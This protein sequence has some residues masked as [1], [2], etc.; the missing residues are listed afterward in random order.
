[1]NIALLKLLELQDDEVFTISPW[2]KHYQSYIT[3]TKIITIKY[4][5]QLVIGY[6]Y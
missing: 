1:M 2:Y 5:P 6:Y 4:N 3:T